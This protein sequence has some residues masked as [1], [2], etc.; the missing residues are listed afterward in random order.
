MSN[1]NNSKHSTILMKPKDVSNKN[2]AYVWTTLYGH[3]LDESP[4]AKFKVDDTV[5]I[6]K[7][8]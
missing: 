2:E 3:L 7:Y 8:K 6:S 1:Y 4:L 5:R